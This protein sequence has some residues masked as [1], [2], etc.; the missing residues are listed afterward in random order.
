MVRGWPQT[1]EEDNNKI[2]NSE[3]VRNYAKNTGNTPRAPSEFFTREVGEDV[4]RARIELDI[5]A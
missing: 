4:S 3:A 5:T 1:K 2:N